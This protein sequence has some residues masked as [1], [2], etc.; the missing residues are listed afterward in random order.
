MEAAV[1]RGGS[2]LRFFFANA[3]I[4]LQIG[5]ITNYALVQY[6]LEVTRSPTLGGFVFFCTFAA[7]GLITIY[8][9]TVLDRI[10]RLHLVTACQPTYV[11]TLSLLAYLGPT[12]TRA[13]ITW[14][15]P[16][17]AILNGLS[18]AFL[19]PGRF[20]LLS[21]L[22]TE[23]HLSRSIVTLNIIIAMTAGLAPFAYGLLR[24]HLDWPGLFATLAAL[25]LIGGLMLTG[26]RGSNLSAY[27]HAPRQA[28]SMTAVLTTLR[29]NSSIRTA[30]ILT[31]CAQIARGVIVV[32]LPQYALSF[33]GLAE[34]ARGAV[35]ASVGVG[36]LI[37]GLVAR[38][39]VGS[40]QSNTLLACA[41]SMTGFPLIGVPFVSDASLLVIIFLSFGVLSGFVIPLLS[42]RIQV[43]APAPVLGR[44]LSFY[45]F[46][47]FLA[48]ATSGLIYGTLADLTGVAISLLVCGFTVVCL[49][50]V[51]I[52]L[53]S[54]LASND[55]I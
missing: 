4:T 52:K 37:G 22:S 36:L 53:E 44:I 24:A 31:A 5:N 38:G 17:I 25:Y 18:L 26:L 10:N 11:I 6:A 40:I 42:S 49:P 54:C 15:L 8:A 1:E 13:Q 34:V 19:Y 14:L 21:S 27:D 20:S 47:S 2:Q 12:A 43:L 48:P 30:L 7:A 35:V 9:G 45:A 51:T 32:L 29:S 46:I 16:L 50:I 3:A 39:A 55:R 23:A 28:Q 33:I 41:V